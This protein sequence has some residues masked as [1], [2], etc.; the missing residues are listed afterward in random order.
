M[1]AKVVAPLTN[2][3]VFSLLTERGASSS[4]MAGT[5]HG[6][7]LSEC[8]VSLLLT[9][10]FQP[11][12]LKWSIM[13][14]GV[15]IPG[16]NSSCDSVSG[17]A[18]AFLDRDKAFQS[19]EVRG[20]TVGQSQTFICGW[21]ALGRFTFCDLWP[22]LMKFSAHTFPSIQSYFFHFFI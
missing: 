10:L 12:T 3:E 13:F 22:G 14:S 2:M 21:N 7:L 9:P 20:C 15:W 4:D 11:V 17:C 18:E 8:R 1:K 5:P 6:P 16:E 19:C